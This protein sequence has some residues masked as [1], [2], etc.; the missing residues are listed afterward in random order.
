M[1]TL[2]SI[3]V[4][5]PRE[6]VWHALTNS[7]AV[8]P[9]YFNSLFEADIRPG[10]ELKYRTP[11][12]QRVLIVGK[13]LEVDP[14]RR[15]VHEFRFT[16]LAEPPQTVAFEL[17]DVAAGTRVTVRHDGLAAAPKHSSRVSHGWDHI[18][19]NLKRW[20]ET[21]SLPLGARMQ[22]AVMHLVLRMMPNKIQA[23]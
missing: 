4:D 11:D 21:G 17:E 6:S 16:D 10:G 1:K 22:N 12:G 18:L 15:L 14:A 3:E 13:V 23:T 9:F 20:M 5:S 19:N 7:G 8:Q 2:W